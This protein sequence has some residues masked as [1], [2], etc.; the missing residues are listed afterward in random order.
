MTR[1]LV[2][3]RGAAALLLA[4]AL[5]AGASTPIAAQT[6]GTGQDL[7]MQAE[8]DW[9]TSVNGRYGMQVS[10]PASLFK[11]SDSPDG[12]D[13]RGFVAENAQLEVFGWRNT[14]GE[15]PGRLKDRLIGTEGY[16]NVTY[17]PVGN[18]WLVVS[19]Y[20]GDKVFYE[21]YIFRGDTVQAFGME[22]PESVRATY[23]PILEGVEDSFQSGG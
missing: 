1:T 20:R 2:R 18:S 15:T 13:G 3:S 8:G 23:D 17:S 14:A 21:K 12:G 19:G 6:G 11:P 7:F 9:Q 5:A 10:Y 4:A 16:E 22:Y